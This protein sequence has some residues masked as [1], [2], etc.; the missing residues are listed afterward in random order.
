MSKKLIIIA[1]AGLVSFAGAFAVAWFTNP[2][3]APPPASAEVAGLLG[4]PPNPKSQ[5]APTAP[6]HNQAEYSKN[7]RQKKKIQ[8]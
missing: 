4:A 7:K 2:T 6:P 5:P 8:N 3:T 1:A